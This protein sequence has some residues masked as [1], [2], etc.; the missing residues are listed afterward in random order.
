LSIAQGGFRFFGCSGVF[1]CILW[2]NNFAT[3]TPSRQ[4]EDLT[5]GFALSLGGFVAIYSSVWG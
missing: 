4:D 1:F 2:Q 3:I 5:Q